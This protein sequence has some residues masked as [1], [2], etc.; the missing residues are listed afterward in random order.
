[1]KT[2][3]CT[4]KPSL[5]TET[6]PR[7]AAIIDPS[8]RLAKPLSPAQRPKPSAGRILPLLAVVVGFWCLSSLSSAKAHVLDVWRLRDSATTAGL[9]AT[10]WGKGICVAVGDLG[11]IVTSTDGLTWS[12]RT[13]GTSA[14]LNSIIFA[15][16]RFV[17]VGESGTIL[18][19]DDGIVWIRHDVGT[20]E[21][22][23][24]VNYGQGT[25][26]AVG[27]TRLVLTS[28]DGLTWNVRNDG[29]RDWYGIVYGNGKF[30]A[31]GGITV[32]IYA[33]CKDHSVLSVSPD[34]QTWTAAG[35]DV[36]QY[37][38]D[39][40]FG[41]GIFVAVGAGGTIMTSADG[42]NWTPQVSGSTAF[43]Y[44]VAF[45]EGT[46]VVVGSPG[47]IILSSTDGAQWTPRNSG[48]T[49]GLNNVT[50]G[51]NS[52]FAVGDS[53]TI[54]Q[55]R[56]F[57]P[58]RLSSPRFLADG[59]FGISVL[60]KVDQTYR[61]EG[62]ADLSAPDWVGAKDFTQTSETLVVVDPDAASFGSRLYRVRPLP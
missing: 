55:S 54:L 41:N 34:A 8:A 4:S 51:R 12:R 26:I 47:G 33:N 6:D 23:F 1:M 30:V 46:F 35:L 18:T 40:A 9:W 2:K 28:L 31:V 39:V 45:G 3:K 29:E 38:S 27:A 60:G 25:F 50:Y 15:N 43:L 49:R 24:D 7:I 13:S 19:S 52:F 20:T 10:A 5:E 56:Y 21:F 14:S 36:G 53:G 11:T 32:C 16:D 58:P 61:L 17:T 59:T 22:L 48:T 37:L 42:E 62:T 57:G 44:N